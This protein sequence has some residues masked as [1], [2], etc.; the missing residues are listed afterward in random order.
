MKKYIQLDGNKVTLIH[1][2]PFD[3]VDGLGK[4]ET[5]LLQTGVLLEEIPEP[6][7]RQGKIALPYYTPAQGFYYEYEDAPAGPATTADIEALRAQI[8]Y[9]GMMTEVL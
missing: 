5:E 4:T 1:N 8:D 3:P 2:L 6:E 7:Q 9:V